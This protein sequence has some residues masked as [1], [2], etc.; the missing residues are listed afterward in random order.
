MYK[1]AVNMG[2]KTFLPD[3]KRVQKRC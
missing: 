2:A 1:Y 3:G